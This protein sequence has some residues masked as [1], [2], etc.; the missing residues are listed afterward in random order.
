MS[1]E[2]AAALRALGQV[3]MLLADRD[4][5]VPPVAPPADDLIALADAPI[6][7]RTL[8]GLIREKRLAAVKLGRRRFVRRSDLA[9]LAT[10]P[11]PTPE[12]LSLAA[13]AAARRVGGK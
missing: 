8:R 10:P 13:R 7:R 12:P 3:L 5:H 6:E 1:A 4:E 9:A 11:A 2:I